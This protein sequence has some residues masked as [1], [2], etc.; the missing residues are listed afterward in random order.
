MCG[1][2]V[3]G[4]RRTTGI[5]GLEEEEKKGGV[6]GFGEGDDKET[7]AGWG[8]GGGPGSGRDARCRRGR[9]GGPGRL[10][11]GKVVGCSRWNPGMVGN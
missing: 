8:A 6:G 5:L 3:Y 2:L 10:G 9:V 4:D 1:G 7:R 11:S